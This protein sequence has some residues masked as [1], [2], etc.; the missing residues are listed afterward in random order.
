MQFRKRK[1]LNV[2]GNNTIH[3]YCLSRKILQCIF[4]VLSLQ[5]YC[6]LYSIRI[7][8]CY[9]GKFKQTCKY[10]IYRFTRELL[11]AYIRHISTS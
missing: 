4:K 10:C 5:S 11:S 2:S 9:F 7:D 8:R 6:G 3:T 1:I